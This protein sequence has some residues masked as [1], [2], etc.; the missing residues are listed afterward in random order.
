MESCPD[1]VP[2]EPLSL[3][4]GLRKVNGVV[5]EIVATVAG[6]LKPVPP[7]TLAETTCAPGGTS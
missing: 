5:E 7:L 3:A 4:V 2:P 6:A 1:T